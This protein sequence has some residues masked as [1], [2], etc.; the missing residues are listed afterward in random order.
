ME[1]MFSARLAPLA[2]SLSAL[3]LA[4]CNEDTAQPAALASM[5]I[6][7]CVNDECLVLDQNGAMLV[8]GDNTYAVTLSIPL[9]NTFIFAEDGQWNLAN[10]NGSQIIKPNFPA[11]RRLLT[12]G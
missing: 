6:P 5:V 9:N 7:V 11:G 3:F 12:P 1:R 10:A 2:F 8:N 4:G